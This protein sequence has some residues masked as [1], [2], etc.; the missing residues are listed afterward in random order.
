MINC[1][2]YGLATLD[3][4]SGKMGIL[5]HF[6]PFKCGKEQDES[7]CIKRFLWNEQHGSLPHDAGSQSVP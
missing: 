3:S 2:K 1:E 5:A 7:I 6:D 4:Q